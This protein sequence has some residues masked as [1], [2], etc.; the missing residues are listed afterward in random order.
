MEGLEAQGRLDGKPR[1]CR[2]VT[3]AV[4]H[5]NLPTV[6]AAFPVVTTG[7]HG[8]VAQMVRIPGSAQVLGASRREQE[9]TVK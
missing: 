9:S 1:R 3:L 4:T 2:A 5:H 6:L 8:N 7:R